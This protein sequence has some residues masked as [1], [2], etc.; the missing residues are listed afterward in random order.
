LLWAE[1]NDQASSVVRVSRGMY[2]HGSVQG[3]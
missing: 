2:Q 1:A 3:A